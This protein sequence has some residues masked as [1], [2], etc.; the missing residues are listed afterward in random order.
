MSHYVKRLS[1]LVFILMPLTVSS[2][3][4]GH[5]NEVVEILP[6][7][8]QV[9]FRG[10]VEGMRSIVTTSLQSGRLVQMPIKKGSRV[11]AGEL[12]A[13]VY[14]PALQA[15]LEQAKA[16]LAQREAQLTA[17][18]LQ[19]QRSQRLV[20]TGGMS[21]SRAEDIHSQWSVAKANVKAARASIKAAQD[22]Y[23]ELKITAPFSGL[24]SDILVREGEYIAPGQTLIQLDEDRHQKARFLVPEKY[25]LQMSEQQTY[26]LKIPGLDTTQPVTMIEFAAPASIASG[27]FEVTVELSETNPRFIG[28]IAE[29]ML[30]LPNTRH[31]VQQSALR[32][33]ELGQSY[34]MMA[35]DSTNK[36]YVKVTALKGDYAEIE[37]P[38]TQGELAILPN[39]FELK[40]N[41]SPSFSGE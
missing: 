6:S 13:Q 15:N 9:E 1:A 26:T 8:S 37:G 14:S 33:D 4:Y 38:L 3:K 25:F 18:E 41:Q 19:W 35:N 2:V 32:Y 17:S 7:H 5:A 21:K 20:K 24:V 34:I 22:A 27:L 31:Q 30:T 28:M 23:N 10:K 11:K 39:R 12:I 40:T 16:I 36:L 29:L